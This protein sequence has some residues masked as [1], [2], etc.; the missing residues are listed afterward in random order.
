MTAPTAD[1][2]RNALGALMAHGGEMM[3]RPTGGW[4]CAHC[5]VIFMDADDD[6]ATGLL[7]TGAAMAVDRLPSGKAYHLQLVPAG[8]A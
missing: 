6:L 8:R 4:C 1:G 3:R 5:G 2:V 7:A